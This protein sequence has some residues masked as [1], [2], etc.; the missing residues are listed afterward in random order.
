MSQYRKGTLTAPFLFISVRM[1]NKVL[2]NN[3]Y[4]LQELTIFQFFI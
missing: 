4:K 3:D 2:R 1:D